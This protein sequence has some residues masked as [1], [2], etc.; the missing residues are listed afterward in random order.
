MK[1]KQYFIATVFCLFLTVS[2]FA[3]VK[4]QPVFSNDISLPAKQYMMAGVQNDMFVQTFLKRWRPYNDFV[5]FSGTAN[6][7]RRYEK[8]A[9]IK[10]PETGHTIIV[11][12]VN[13]D[14]FEVTKSITSTIFTGEPGVG[15]KEVVVQFIGDSYTR[16]EYFKNA[17]LKKGYV[18]KVKCV[19]LRR[20][21]DF[22]EQFHEGRGGWTLESYFSNKTEIA[23]YFNP[24]LQPQKEY[25]YWGTTAFWKNAYGLENKTISTETFE[26]KYS[27]ENYD[28]S[29]FNADGW[30]INPKTD[31]IIFDS[32]SKTYQKWNGKSWK[33]IN[34]EKLVWS[35]QYPKY[36][37]M[38]NITPPKFVVIMLGL[39][40][41][42]SKS[43]PADY[44]TWNTRIETLLAS[45]KTAVP[46]GKLIL[47]TPSTSCGSLNNAT[48]D[49]TTRHNATMWEHRKNI[50]D[51]FDNR[52]AE[53]IYIVDASISI[54][55]EHGYN[56]TNTELPYDGYLGTQRLTIQNGNPHPYLSY[57]NMGISIAAFIQY[58]REK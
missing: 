55:N 47:C 16:G 35:F 27:C 1:N 6:Y 56:A 18:P 52:E 9:S 25:R 32:D 19:G 40:D 24:F 3:Q 26:P 28:C 41:F 14:K 2:I 12:L 15:S 23:V 13:G 21:N 50:I 20:V 17:I 49:F 53:G 8:V 29:K 48:G 51:V 38:W 46:N 30:L 36:L 57:P 54:D 11:D 4:S 42:R 37:S 7:V 34:T 44:S 5:R 43:I 10:E 58:Y 31:D 22:P 33:K 45:Y 39:N